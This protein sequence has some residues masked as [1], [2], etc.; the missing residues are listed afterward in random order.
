[1]YKSV[2]SVHPLS[3]SLFLSLLKNMAIR[4]NEKKLNENL[5]TAMQNL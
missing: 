3:L 2:S 5:F 1:M 4:H